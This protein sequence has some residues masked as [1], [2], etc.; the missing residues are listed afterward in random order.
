M[1]EGAARS[2]S[3]WQSCSGVGPALPLRSALTRRQG[4]S[5]RRHRRRSRTRSSVTACRRRRDRGPRLSC[6]CVGRARWHSRASSSSHRGDEVGSDGRRIL[7]A[8]RRGAGDLDGAL[9]DPGRGGI[10]CMR[11]HRRSGRLSAFARCLPAA[12]HVKAAQALSTA[13]APFGS[14]EPSATSREAAGAGTRSPTR[15][16]RATA[17]TPP[18]FRSRSRRRRAPR[19]RW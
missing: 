12:A 2:A 1:V 11:C 16:G 3:R 6:R 19:R 13:S 4:R 7:A 15:P 8:D 17:P 5:P 9:R 10:R 14:H 18:A